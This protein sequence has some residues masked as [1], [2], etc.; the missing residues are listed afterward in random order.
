MADR[1]RIIA[2]GAVWLAIIVGGA[3]VGL[4]AQQ[5]GDYWNG[6]T[7]GSAA[8]AGVWFL[9]RGFLPTSLAKENVE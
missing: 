2:K 7:S 9:F 8:T 6:W 4:V 5:W 3:M 1:Y